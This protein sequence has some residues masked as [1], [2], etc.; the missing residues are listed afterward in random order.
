VGAYDL[1]NIYPYAV[2][3]KGEILCSEPTCGGL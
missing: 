1:I 3:V 2:Y